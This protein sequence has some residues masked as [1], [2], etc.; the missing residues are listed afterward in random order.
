MQARGFS[1]G[2][3]LENSVR[4][5]WYNASETVL[6]KALDV[7]NT[8]NVTLDELTWFERAKQRESRRISISAMRARVQGMRSLQAFRAYIRRH[9]GGIF[10][11]WRRLLDKDGSM[12]VTRSEFHVAVSHQGW[13]GDILALWRELDPEGK[14]FTTLEDFAF[15]EARTLALFKVWMSANFGDAK[16]MMRALNTVNGSHTKLSKSGRLT[17]DMWVG[18]CEKKKCPADFREVFALLDLDNTGSVM[19]KDFICLDQ[20]HITSDWLL[21]PPSDE[22]AK[23]VKDHLSYRYKAPLKAWVKAIDQTHTCKVSWSDFKAALE[24]VGFKGDVAGAWHAF[25]SDQSGYITLKEFDH[26]AAITL[27]T[28][29]CWADDEFGGVVHALEQMDEHGTGA[30]SCKDFKKKIKAYGYCHDTQYLFNCLDIDSKG[31]LQPHDL[32]FL[33][34]WELAEILDVDNFQDFS[35]SEDGRSLVEESQSDEGAVG[36][37]VSPR[38]LAGTKRHRHAPF[39][40]RRS[41]LPWP[42]INHGERPPMPSGKRSRLLD[43]CVVGS[44]ARGT[45][46]IVP[47]HQKILASLGQRR[48]KLEN[49][50][51]FYSTPDT[52]RNP[53][54]PS[55]E[56]SQGLLH[57]IGWTESRSAS[58]E[59]DLVAP[60]PNPE[61][62][63]CR[64]PQRCGRPHGQTGRIKARYITRA[65]WEV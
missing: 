52:G 57:A 26:Q 21:Q 12:T 23:A 8:G 60:S 47:M 49:R 22:A 28:F 3:F 39:K 16:A 59:L 31:H 25:D 53:P 36:K 63:F 1:K 54:A 29:R 32:Y 44:P 6:F 4:F 18:A 20:W 37:K 64:S 61:A 41:V 48:D 65:A 38:A 9:H 42:R 45:K 56:A 62:D 27:A 17:R 35:D 13:S 19:L 5:G 2:Q 55:A 46:R 30:L 50:A 40:S 33:D 10:K 51:V 15:A 24:Q 11:A 34:E 7:N 43:G 14:G 58:P